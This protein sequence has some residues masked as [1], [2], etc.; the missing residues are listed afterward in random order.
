LG[1]GKREEKDVDGLKYPYA[2]RCRG[3]GVSE[4]TRDEKEKGKREYN[5]V[6]SMS[7]P[8]ERGSGRFSQSQERNVK[9]ER[10]FCSGDS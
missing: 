5:Y 7:N 3:G 6:L 1:R 8:K 4:G 9:K 10:E 2:W